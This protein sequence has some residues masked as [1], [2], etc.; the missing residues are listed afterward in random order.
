MYEEIAGA[1][2]SARHEWLRSR[3]LG[4]KLIDALGRSRLHHHCAGV[5]PY[6]RIL[7]EAPPAS[8]S[9]CGETSLIMEPS[10]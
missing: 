9:S 2:V 3:P 6:S 1:W 10:V 8:T 5:T 4:T 7:L